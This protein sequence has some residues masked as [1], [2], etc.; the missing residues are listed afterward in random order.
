MLKKGVTFLWWIKSS[1]QI[2]PQQNHIPP[3]KRQ[4]IT[5]YSSGFYTIIHCLGY[6]WTDNQTPIPAFIQRWLGAAHETWSYSRGRQWEWCWVLEGLVEGVHQLIEGGQVG[7]DL[8]LQQIDRKRKWIYSTYVYI[9]YK[10]E[11]R[12]EM[13]M[14]SLDWIQER[15]KRS[16]T[17]KTVFK[18]PKFVR[19]K[20]KKKTLAV[21][22]TA[23]QRI[24]L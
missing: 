22:R 12:K 23:Y 15:E 4:N 24:A 20:L 10:Q 3:K 1:G 14:P 13:F 18:N 6:L 5:T 16:K 21:H 2:I 11:T 8:D 7:V 19:K 9:E 17:F